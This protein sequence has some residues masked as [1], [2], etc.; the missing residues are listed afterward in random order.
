MSVER[1]PQNDRRGGGSALIA[2]L[3]VLVRGVVPLLLVALA[4]L[5]GPTLVVWWVD[6][7]SLSW[8]YVLIGGAISAALLVLIGLALGWAMGQLGRGRRR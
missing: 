6:G 7:G 8:R 4:L 5:I 1:Q 2:Q 3:I